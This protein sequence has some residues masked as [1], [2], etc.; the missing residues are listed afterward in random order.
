LRNAPGAFLK[1]AVFVPAGHETR[2]AEA[3]FAAGAGGVGNYDQC[4]FRVPGTGT[5]RPGE[6]ANPFIGRSGQREEVEELRL[7]VLVPRSRLGRVLDRMFR[8]H[9]Y[10]EVAYDLIP[11]ENQSPGAGLGRI[12]RLEKSMPLN[13]FAAGVK[14]ALNCSAV[15]V[16]GPGETVV[17]KVA[18][19]GGSGAELLRTAHRQGAD[20]IVTGDVK[21]HEARAAEEMGIAIVDAGHFA[22]E[23]LMVGALTGL[24][25]QSAKAHGWDLFFD[26]FTKE[27]DPFRTC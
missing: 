16:V 21:Y 12:G 7:E 23:H 2:V 18:V 15:R 17:S 25:N 20:V 22:T 8:E 10:E 5:F 27:T 9:P 24:L 4:S 11:L 14:A 6:A 19:C 3:L 1:L 13:L 26:P